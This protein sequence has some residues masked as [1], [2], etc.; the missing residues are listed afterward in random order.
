MDPHLTYDH[1]LAQSVLAELRT[2]TGRAER[3]FMKFPD[4]NF[5]IDFRADDCDPGVANPKLAENFLGDFDHPIEI[6]VAT[7]HAA[8]AQDCRAAVLVGG[9]HHMTVIGLDRI[10]LEIG[11]ACAKVVRT[12]IHRPGITNEGIDPSPQ[13]MP[14]RLARIAVSERAAGRHYAVDEVRHRIALLERGQPKWPARLTDGP[15]IQTAVENK[16]GFNMQVS[17]KAMAAPDRDQLREKAH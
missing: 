13:R 17:V 8:A 14:Q 4:N 15:L 12:R 3:I 1:A 7:G 11:G 9:F 5:G 10:A 2:H 6:A 16:Y